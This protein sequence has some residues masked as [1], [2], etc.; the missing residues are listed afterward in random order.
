MINEEDFTVDISS[1]AFMPDKI[2][3]KVTH[4]PSGL[5]H[6]AIGSIAECNKEVKQWMSELEDKI[7]DD[8]N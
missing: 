8:G 1:H 5:T 7:N 3:K 2:I 6:V 4:V